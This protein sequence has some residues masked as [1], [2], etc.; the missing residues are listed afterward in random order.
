MEIERITRQFL[1]DLTTTPV[2]PNHNW[3]LAT[4]PVRSSGLGLLKPSSQSFSLSYALTAAILHQRYCLVPCTI[5]PGGQLGPLTSS[6][7]W[8]RKRHPTAILPP[9]HACSIRGIPPARI[10]ANTAACISLIH[11]TYCVHTVLSLTDDEPHREQYSVVVTCDSCDYFSVS[12]FLKLQVG[13]HPGFQSVSGKHDTCFSQHTT[14]S[15]SSN[16]MAIRLE[17]VSSRLVPSRPVPSLRPF[18]LVTV[19]ISFCPCDNLVWS[20][21][22][23]VGT[24]L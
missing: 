23:T 18:R 10:L 21:F 3:L 14:H 7:L 24:R 17:F 9:S 5:D 6:L 11:C 13:Q 12:L 16:T 1:C 20:R 15:S 22:A 4:L 8:P 19:T 2:L